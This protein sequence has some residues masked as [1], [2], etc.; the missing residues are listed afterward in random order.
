MIYFCL[1]FLLVSY[2]QKQVKC[3]FQRADKTE[4]SFFF[5]ECFSMLHTVNESFSS[6][7]CNPPAP[8][9]TQVNITESKKIV[10]FKW[11]LCL[12]SD[13]SA[14]SIELLCTVAFKDCVGSVCRVNV[15]TEKVEEIEETTLFSRN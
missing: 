14:Y 10:C 7:V 12:M 8:P 4:K 13:K 1:S 15:E 11:I 9:P 3:S 5:I 2:I 6:Q